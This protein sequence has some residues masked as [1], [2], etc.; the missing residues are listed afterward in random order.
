MG[1][2]CKRSAFEIVGS[3]RNKTDDIVWSGWRQSAGVIP[4][5]RVVNFHEHHGF[6]YQLRPDRPSL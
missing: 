1:V 2:G 3:F 6:K 5:E 4:G